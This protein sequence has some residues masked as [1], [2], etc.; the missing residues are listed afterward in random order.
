MPTV[1]V[2]QKVHMRAFCAHGNRGNSRPI[3]RIDEKY[4]K[5][6]KHQ[7]IIF[8]FVMGLPILNI[9]GQFEMVM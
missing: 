3:Q 5:A 1:N 4:C 7:T 2:L 6:M 8:V 9:I